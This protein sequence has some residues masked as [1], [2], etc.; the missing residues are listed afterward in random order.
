MRVLKARR[1]LKV[2]TGT[3]SRSVSVWKK[4]VY[5]RVFMYIGKGV[6]VCVCTEKN[7]KSKYPVCVC[8]CIKPQLRRDV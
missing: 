3:G 5:E 8:L 7:I 1:D 4:S 2:C 6:C